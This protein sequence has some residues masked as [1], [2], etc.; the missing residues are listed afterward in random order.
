VPSMRASCTGARTRAVTALL[1]FRNATWLT[2]LIACCRDA[3]IVDVELNSALSSVTVETV[4][5]NQKVVR[6]SLLCGS[7]IDVS[8]MS[9]PGDRAIT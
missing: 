1:L 8:S 3:A 9:V 6:R 5:T 4:S 2:P 7:N